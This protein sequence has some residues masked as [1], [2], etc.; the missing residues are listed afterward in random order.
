M[1]F[2]TSTLQLIS[3]NR[4]MN[5]INFAG[6]RNVLFG[7]DTLYGGKDNI[8]KNLSRIVDLEISGED[9]ELI[10]GGNMERILNI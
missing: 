4:L 1:Y 3:Q 9:K 2:D 5:A 6:V 7:T 8:R 10:L